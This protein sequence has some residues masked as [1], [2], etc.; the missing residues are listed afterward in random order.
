MS[1]TKIE[2]SEYSWN[3]VVGCSK[4]SVGCER[5]YALR[6]AVRLAHN[7]KLPDET[8]E[9][10]ASTVR[11]VGDKWQWSG[12][13]ALF[14]ERLKEPL[15]RR[16]PTR[17]FVPSMSDLFHENVPLDFIEQVYDVMAEAK[18]HT[19]QVLTKRP[20]RAADFLLNYILP[21]PRY[22]NVADV[23]LI[24]KNVWLGVTAENQA[25]ADER[26]PL[27]LQIPAAVRFVSC[28]PLL[29]VVDLSEY[30]MCRQ[31][32]GEEKQPK[33]RTIGGKPY[34]VMR[35]RPRLSWLIVGGESGPGARPMH[36]DWARSLV[37]QGKAANVP[38]FVK[39]MGAHWAKYAE[40]EGDWHTTVKQRGDSK[41]HDM[42]YWPE[43]LQVR[44]MPEVK[45]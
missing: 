8:R 32:A 26:I 45:R 13:V 19:F 5:C 33:P 38:V 34:K 29:G 2:W 22:L 3:P 6:M 1:K 12:K 21:S 24:W 25:V 31:Y 35:I 16:R 17:Y 37:Q 40:P 9:K 15:K 23:P 36:P 27:L 42:R 14:P 43:D 28:E 30:L 41:G 18:Q 10:Y 11:K 20:R 39:Q 4:R 7:P 44:E